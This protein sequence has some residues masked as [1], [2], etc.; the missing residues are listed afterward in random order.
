MFTKQFDRF[1]IR[2]FNGE[3]ISNMAYDKLFDE[4]NHMRRVISKLRRKKMNTKEV[5]VELSYLVHE[6]DQRK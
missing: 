6:L 3:E 1:E 2:L 5:E 4:I